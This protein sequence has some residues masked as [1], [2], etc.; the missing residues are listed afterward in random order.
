M[1]QGIAAMHTAYGRKA[2]FCEQCRNLYRPGS[3]GF[4]SCI[5]YDQSGKTPWDK[6]YHA[7][8]MTR[9]DFLAT[10]KPDMLTQLRRAQERQK[11]V[12]DGQLTL[13]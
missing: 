11:A 8:G 12:S 7:C 13:F 2:T 4:C 5:A 9:F 6:D 3:S 1:R 10:G